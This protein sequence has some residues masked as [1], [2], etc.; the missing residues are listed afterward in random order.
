MA[1]RDID[2][3]G[4]VV[5]GGVA[6]SESEAGLSGA[7]PRCASRLV[8]DAVDSLWN[9]A[10][11]CGSG[12]LAEWVAFTQGVSVSHA[13]ELPREGWRPDQGEAHLGERTVRLLAPLC[14]PG[15]DDDALLDA[16]VA[17]Y[18]SALSSSEQAIGWLAQLGIDAA[19]TTR[20]RIGVAN[21]TLGYRLP[22]AN[23]KDGATLRSR[24]TDLGVYRPSGHEHLTG[25]VVI[26]V[27]EGGRVVGL[28]GYRLDRPDPP[29]WASGLPGGLF[30]ATPNT[31]GDELIVVTS[32][33]DALA[34]L[35]TGYW[36]VVAPGRP[37]GFSRRDLAT[38]ANAIDRVVVIGDRADELVERFA[39]QGIASRVVAPGAP[40]ADLLPSARDQRHALRALLGADTHQTPPTPLPSRAAAD[41]NDAATGT[42]G[43]S[44]ESTVEG[45]AAE[46]FVTVG[47]RR[48]RV[49]GADRNRVPDALRVALSVTDLASGTFHLD[50]LDLYAAKARG[51]F[52]DAAASELSCDPAALR[53][54]LAEVL[55]ATETTITAI[56]DNTATPVM[57]GEERE[58]AF[59]LLRDP[60]LLE[61]IIV[62][63]GGL[64]VVGEQTNLLVA[65]LATISRKAERPFGVVIQSSS[66]A[67]KST[68][69]DA[70]CSLVPEEDLASF[71]ALTGQALYYVSGQS[72]A[73]KVLA[74]AEEQGA[75]RASYALKLL[76]TEGRLSIGSTGKDPATGR[77]RTTSYQV[78]GPV[79]LVL[80]TTATDIDPELANRVIVLGIDEDPDQTRAIHAAQRRAV[81]LDGMVA[82]LRRDRLLAL[83]RNAQRLL[84]ALPVV[85]PDAETLEF[86]AHAVRHRRDH[87]KLLALITASALLHQYQR[88]RGT[89]TIDGDPVTYLEA[90]PADITL[91]LRLAETVLARTGDELAPQTRRMLAAAQTLTA[92]RASVSN[93][94][95]VASARVAFTRRELRERLGAS[96]HQ[97]RVGLAR[98]VALE[99][100]TVVPGPP[101]HPNR[102]ALV[103]PPDAQEPCDTLRDPEASDAQGQNTA[104][105]AETSNPVDP[106]THIGQQSRN[107]DVGTDPRGGATPQRRRRRTR[108]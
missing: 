25:C 71:S 59:G 26:S 34:V 41:N 9:C 19:L 45:D 17:H 89:V 63:L 88:T 84:D 50:T 69:A 23:R 33:R 53:R 16:V 96:E 64:G 22:Q 65:Y 2:L 46:L 105:P 70:V 73:H 81:T 15:A 14:K 82:R 29:R 6:L 51:A 72:L 12:G 78:A 55:F 1:V 90:A 40:I 67:G 42:A 97:V 30:P 21:R 79:A 80:T 86:P 93:A 66:A 10:G 106:E 94:S 11:G 37:S 60:G 7:C 99:Y 107:V 24:L 36:S 27:I 49:R 77:L 4:L 31:G 75:S 76:L 92:E 103:N 5:A 68:L 52:I 102:Y 43:S 54:E 20:L 57:T 18:A 83:H 100:L 8:V 98:L 87:Q 39:K 58:S 13:G 85:I 38:I 48:W 56:D 28:C 62:D 61:R 47:L 95:S 101:G 3:V 74:V 108:R 44:T 35:A 91:A 32:I 104:R